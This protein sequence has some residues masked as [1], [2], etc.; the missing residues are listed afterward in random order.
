LTSTLHNMSFYAQPG[1]TSGSFEGTTYRYL[2]IKPSGTKPVLLLL[3]GFPSGPMSFRPLIPLLV[4]QGYGVIAPD[5]L[6]YGGTDKPTDVQAYSRPAMADALAAMLDKEM[7]E[8]VVVLGHDHGSPVASSF[9]RFYPKRSIALVLCAV[10]YSPPNPDG[11]DIQKI[12]AVTTPLVGYE[13]FGYWGFFAQ[14]N[15]PA[16]ISE[17]MDSFVS[18]LYPKDPSV[19]TTRFA[20]TGALEKNLRADYR[21]EEAE[22]VS[23]SE[24]KE[25]KEYLHSTGLAG[26]LKWY[27]A[28]VANIGYER[29]KAISTRLSLPYLFLAAKKDFIAIPMLAATQHELCDDLTAKELD[30]C[31]WVC[32]EDPKG[33]IREISDFLLAKGLLS[34]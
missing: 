30:T 31:H 24:K 6:G 23:D 25:L 26:P 17:H 22:W 27:E 2:S 18:L 16:L 10:G 12:M 20:P 19:W 34:K 7:V 15:A 11:F 4:E 21:C 29:E 1:W 32:E 33:V 28:S 3:H 8:S 5:L 13:L 9:V 14:A